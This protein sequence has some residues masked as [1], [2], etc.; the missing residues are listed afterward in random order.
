MKK[1]VLLF[2]SALLVLSSCNG[3]KQVPNRLEKL[4]DKIEARGDDFSEEDWNKVSAEY[5]EIIQQYSDHQDKYTLDESKRVVKAVGR[6]HALVIKRGF[7]NAASFVN[8]IISNAPAYLEGLGDAIEETEEDAK[9]AIEEGA[10]GVVDKISEGVENI[11][12]K[13]DN[14][15]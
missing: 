10:E 9:E 1:I 5:D 8:D 12:D 13:L 6:Y 2:V 11:L 14:L 15:F 4:V 7:K 3:W